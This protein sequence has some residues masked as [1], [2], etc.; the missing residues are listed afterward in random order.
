MVRTMPY[1][2]NLQ[3]MGVEVAYQPYY[4]SVPDYLALHGHEFDMVIISRAEIASRY[5]EAVRTLAPRA[6]LVFDT[7]D[8]H[9]VR[10]ERAA[11]LM[12]DSSLWR[13]ARRRKRQELAIASQCD[14]TLVVSPVE[15]E[16]L[17]SECPG[18]EVRL[19]PNVIDVPRDLPPGYDDRRHLLFVGGFGHDP[20]I[21]AVFYFVETI[22]PLIVERLPNVLF[23]VVGS[24]VPASIRDL[25]GT[26]VQVVGFVPDVEPLLDTAR[27]SVAP[28]RFGAGVKGKVNQSMAFGVPTVVTSIAAE[29]MHLVHEESAMIAEDPASFADA[30]VRLWTS[31]PLWERLS[32]NGRESVREHFSVE[33]ANRR[34]DELLA[35]AGLDR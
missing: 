14:A 28:L 21:D 32:K 8:L 31:K 20:N 30:V 35:F 29:G 10:E 12:N 15:K 33:T 25:A 27:V 13:A 9:F 24:N 26:N 3:R 2:Q 4:S 23:Q 19:L 18:I 6:K 11:H 5:F 1:A 7:V 34:I 16:I 17:E 22:L